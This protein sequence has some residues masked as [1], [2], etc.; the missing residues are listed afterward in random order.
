MNSK[1]KLVRLYAAYLAI[2]AIK[3]ILYSAGFVSGILCLQNP[4]ELGK[5]VVKEITA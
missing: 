5:I 2:P 4:H 3:G 1:Y